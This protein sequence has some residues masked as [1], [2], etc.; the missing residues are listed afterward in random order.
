M[1]TIIDLTPEIKANIQIYK[2]KAVNDLYNGTENKNWNRK[3]TV[4][5]IEYVYKLGKQEHKPIVVIAN[6]PLEYRQYYNLIF[7]DKINDKYVK[8]IN[9]M[10]CVKN[11]KKVFD[12]AFYKELQTSTNSEVNAEL[13]SEIDKVPNHHWLFLTSEYSRIYLMW[14]KFLQDEFK[15]D[16][17]KS[18]E[19]NWLYEKVNSANIAKSYLCEKV[20]LILR[21]PEKINRVNNNFHCQTDAAIIYKNQK[22]YYIYGVKIT[23]EILTA[24][25]N[26]TYTFK[27]FSLEKNEEIKSAILNFFEEN[28]GGEYVFRFLSEYLKEIDTYVHKKEEKYL[29]NTTQ[30]QNIGVYTLF[31]GNINDIDIAY[32]RCFCPS[33]DRMFFLGVNNEIDNA[34]DAIASLCQVPSELKDN[35]VSI[36][37]CGEIYS[38]NFDEKGINKIKNSC[39]D[40]ENVVSLSGN[41]YFKKL[42]WEY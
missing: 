1:K 23:E 22:L 38:F 26:K 33:T 18:E 8:L 32:V 37:R 35:L 10:W 20:V 36:T 34:K 21:M 29:E 28:Y 11:N 6:N 5:Y 7:N 19:L 16:N 15:L 41:D 12:A 31:K 17:K 24:L 39:I 25:N 27:D 4:E 9:Y 14:Y 40:V 13:S 3:D 2:D 30:S 42:I